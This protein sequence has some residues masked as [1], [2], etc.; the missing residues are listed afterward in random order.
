MY[1]D[2]W[3]KFLDF[4]LP[5]TWMFVLIKMCMISLTVNREVKENC[6]CESYFIWRSSLSGTLNIASRILV[7]NMVGFSVES[8]FKYIQVIC[9]DDEVSVNI[10]RSNEICPLFFDLTIN[11]LSLMSFILL[12]WW[13]DK[14]LRCSRAIA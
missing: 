9:V 12:R 5:K 6:Y 13:K 10:S 3:N 1:I 2:A 14:N 7:I 11:L 8:I 4:G